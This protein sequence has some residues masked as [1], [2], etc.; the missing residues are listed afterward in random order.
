MRRPFGVR[1]FGGSR[2]DHPW[3]QGSTHHRP[4][5]G[6]IRS[7]GAVERLSDKERRARAAAVAAAA[8]VGRAGGDLSGVGSGYRRHGCRPAASSASRPTRGAKPSWSLDAPPARPVGRRAA[9]F[10]R[11]PARCGDVHRRSVRRVTDDAEAAEL[12]P[13]EE[14][15][16]ARS[17]ETGLVEE[18]ETYIYTPDELQVADIAADYVWLQKG[19]GR[20]VY[21]VKK[22]QGPASQG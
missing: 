5:S 2:A 21:L 12:E 13:R 4:W 10:D 15:L 11:K 16:A 8:V 17:L 3:S 19:T 6:S 7:G 20:K 1:R 14:L 18:D 9:R 22:E